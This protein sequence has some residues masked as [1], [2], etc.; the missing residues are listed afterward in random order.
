MY[1]LYSIAPEHPAFPAPGT[2]VYASVTVEP[3]TAH[4]FP[5]VD[6]NQNEY[7]LEQDT[8]TFINSSTSTGAPPDA[9]IDGDE[10]RDTEDE[11]DRDAEGLAEAEA[12]GERED[13]GERDCEAEGESEEEGL[14]DCDADGERDKEDDAEGDEEEEGERDEMIDSLVSF[15]RTLVSPGVLWRSN[16]THSATEPATPEN[17]ESESPLSWSRI[18]EDF[19]YIVY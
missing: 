16:P 8:A 13:E 6:E 5:L 7:P 18:M 10:D 9:L 14:F 4:I 12:L 19:I 1:P 17:L 15:W 3:K 11:G 2:V